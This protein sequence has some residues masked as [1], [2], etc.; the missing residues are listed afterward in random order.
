MLG[1]REHATSNQLKIQIKFRGCISPLHLGRSCGVCL[2]RGR[3]VLRLRSILRLQYSKLLKDSVSK[4]PANHNSHSHSRPALP[5]WR[6]LETGEQT[7]RDTIAYH[8]EKPPHRVR[9]LGPHTY[10]VL[11]PV[12]IKPDILVQLPRLIVRV[13]LWYRVVGAYNF[14]GLAVS[15]R[16]GVKWVSSRFPSVRFLFPCFGAR[17]GRALWFLLTLHVRRR[18]CKKASSCARS[19][20]V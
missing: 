3:W 11:C 12:D 9:R 15:R 14:E 20:R 6:A 13:L 16:P 8:R 2:Q 7:A 4:M 1:C 19:G 5:F 10:P 17:G 18:C